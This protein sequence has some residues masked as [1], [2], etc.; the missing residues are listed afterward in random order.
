MPPF[1]CSNQPL[2]RATA[3]VKAPCFVTEQLGVDQ[4]GRDGAA[5]DPAERAAAEGRV[6]V[7]GAGDDFLAGAGFAE[8]EHGRG[9]ARDHLRPR[10]DRGEAGIAADQPLVAVRLAAGR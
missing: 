9:A 6:F 5:V 8:Q 7:D 2:R 3:P 10:H 4:L 1:A